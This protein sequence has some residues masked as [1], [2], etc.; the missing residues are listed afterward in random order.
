M[1]EEKEEH[2]SETTR[3]TIKEIVKRDGRLVEFDINKIKDAIFR[4][5]ES[6]GGKDKELAHSLALKVFDLLNE[7]FKN[8]IPTV[9]N[10]QDIV[11]KILIEEGHAQTA[12]AYIL[13]RHKK[14]EERERRA[15]ITGAEN[16]KDN[17]NFSNEALEILERRYLLKDKEGVVNESPKGML[18]RVAENISQADKLYGAIE[19]EIKKVEEKF[20]NIMAELKF[21]PN[22]PTLMNAGTETQQLSSCFVLPIEDTMEG[23]FGALKDAA[24]IHQRGSGTGFSFSRLRPKGDS[25]KTNIGVASGPVAFMS[26]YDK[27]L[28]TIKQG[29]VRPGANMAVLRVD[30][31]DIIRFI[32]AKRNRRALQNFNISVAI[33]DRFMR[34]VEADREYYVINPKSEKN[35]GKLRARDVFAMI[36]QNAWKTGD[37]GLIFIDEINR[38]HPAKDLGEIETTNQCGE[39]PLLPYEGI[40]LG[41]INLNEFINS[42]SNDLLWE[43]LKETV[44]TAVHFL[45]NVIDMNSYP[46]KQIESN[47]KRTRKFGLG[48]M[49]LADILARLRIK[50]DSDEGLKTAEKLMSFIKE[51]AY[52]MSSELAEKRGVCPAWENSEHHKAGRKMRNM[53]CISISPTGTISLLAGASSGCEP[54][55]AISYQRSLLG[56]KELV[57]LNPHFEKVAKEKGFYSPRLIRDIARAG[58]IQDFKEIP[59]SVRDVFVTAQDINP[60]GHIKMQ[61]TLQNN[62]DN[63]ISKTINFPKIAAIKDVENAYLLAWKSK[64]KGITIYRDGSYEEQVI[65]IGEGR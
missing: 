44:R 7:Q 60:E 55:F 34:S 58:S 15:L 52:Q 61:A 41:S 39:A 23:I 50:Y 33:T 29:G 20:Y 6:V 3:K 65:T 62:V 16:T 12:K 43:N 35:V 40:V 11:E 18:K 27:A 1:D 53:T 49:G 42:A 5:A 30:H 36:T 26:V 22:S 17:L 28:E 59:K 21:L 13:H 47:T 48:I 57:Y 8:S 24:L 31:P 54:F 51:T 32:E 45:D 9:D 2:I 25:V 37:P 19:E 46:N 4:A 64:C 10:V 63:S 14:D 56:N 38:K